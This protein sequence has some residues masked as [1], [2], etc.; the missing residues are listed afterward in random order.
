MWAGEAGAATLGDFALRMPDSVVAATPEKG[1]EP[2][3]LGLAVTLAIFPGFGLGHYYADDAKRALT[4]VMLDGATALLGVSTFVLHV[5][6]VAPTYTKVALI[7][8]PA[9]FA[10]VKVIEAVDVADAVEVANNRTLRPVSLR[11]LPQ[12]APALAVCRF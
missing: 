12:N 3:S 8:F 5:M 4:F 2:L 11:H 6:S 10:T 9:V 1:R 7:A